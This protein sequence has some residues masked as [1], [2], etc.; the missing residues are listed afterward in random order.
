M[1]TKQE[2]FLISLKNGYKNVSLYHTIKE[3]FWEETQKTV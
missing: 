1:N 3:K 2:N